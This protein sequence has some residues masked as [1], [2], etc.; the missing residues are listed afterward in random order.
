MKKYVFG[1]DVG[2][3]SVKIGLFMTDGTLKEMW[4]I[5]TRTEDSGNRILE[6]IWETI[7]AKMEQIDI[8]SKEIEGLGMGIPGPV[9]EDGT[10]QGCVNLGWNTFNI[11][12]KMQN[13][14]GIKTKAGNDANVAALG[15][16]WQG[17]G[18]G[19]KNIVMVTLGTG[20]GG[21]VILD[22]KIL[23]GRNGAAG[24]IGHLP[25]NEEETEPCGCG[26]C[27]CLEQYASATGVVRL[28]K[29]FLEDQTEK[30]LLSEVDILNAKTVLDA[31]RQG[32]PV[33]LKTLDKAAG[34]LGKGLANIACVL[35]PDAFV[36]GGGMAKSGEIL[37]NAIRKYFRIYTFPVS[38]ETEFY[39]AE[40]GNQAGIYGSAKLVMDP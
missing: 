35:N 4:E 15:E 3:T 31:A 32:D 7:S 6:D 18:K 30:S 22:G 36:I 10:V 5:P 26:K 39:L 11:E 34:Y 23:S 24:E 33:A 40:L 16:M 1:I 2:G 38:K 8:N 19:T 20:V 27:G 17:G 29:R 28:A 9:L 21:G 37:L 12:K 14:T 25:M 13:L